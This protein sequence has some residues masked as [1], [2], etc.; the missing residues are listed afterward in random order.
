MSYLVYFLFCTLC[1]ALSIH[2]GFSFCS[3]S[4]LAH[5]CFYICS[6]YLKMYT[7]YPQCFFILQFSIPFN[8]PHITFHSNYISITIVIG[9]SLYSFHFCF[10]NHIKGNNCMITILFEAFSNFFILHPNSLSFQV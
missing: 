4:S 8:S 9:T 6:K 2:I 7:I 5:T 1:A 3:Q 10:K